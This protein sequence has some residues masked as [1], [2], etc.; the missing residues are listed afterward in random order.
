MTQA[1][2]YQ[3]EQE[4]LENAFVRQLLIKYNIKEVTTQK[5]AING[6]REFE[7]P[8]STYANTN[9]YYKRWLISSGTKWENTPRLRL[10]CFKSGYVR[11]QNGCYSPYQINKTYN[12]E[13]RTTF[14]IDGKLQTRKFIG[15]AR[16]KVRSSLARLNYM[17][18]Y[19][20]KNYKQ[21]TI[22]AR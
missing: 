9:A 13:Q 6:T 21:N 2:K 15:K 17:L 1:T 14:L 12:Q 20:L 16:A 18:E 4:A 10:A 5:Q 19:Y 11:K 22:K 7:F 8:V 3:L